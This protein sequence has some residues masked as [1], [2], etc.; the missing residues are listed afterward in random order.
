VIR[1]ITAALV[2]A[3][4]VPFAA[5]AKPEYTA[6]CNR[7]THDLT[8]TWTGGTDATARATLEW[9]DGTDEIVTLELPKQGG[10]RTNTWTNLG[11]QSGPLAGVAVQFVRNNGFLPSPVRASCS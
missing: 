8:L 2:L 6:T 7:N 11:S 3:A 1:A 10:L 9:A 4:L 5:G